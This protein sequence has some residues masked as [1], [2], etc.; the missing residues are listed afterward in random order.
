MN[1]LDRLLELLFA[2]RGEQVPDLD[3][4]Q[5]ADCFRALCNV[6]P[7]RPAGEEFLRLQ[8]DYLSAQAAARGPVD[9]ADLG[10]G[11]AVLWRGDI[12]RLR[13]DAIVNACNPALLGC[14]HPLH[15]CIDNLIHSRAGVQVRLDCAA[16]MRGECEPNGRVRVT[17]AYNL[18]CRLIFHTV[19]PVVSGAVT[20]ENRQ[21]LR[22][23]Y[24]SCLAEAERRKLTGIAFCCLSTGVYRFPKR[25]ACRIALAAVE[26]WLA[27]HPAAPKVVFCVYTDED[28]AVYSA[29]FSNTSFAL[30]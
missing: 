7:P 29:E 21:D 15:N 3:E 16:T 20:E 18:P 14:F 2:E 27:V 10:G 24:I 11:R 25:E 23:C 1:P 19:G 6:R 22:A 30:R 5:K 4:S 28:E 12:T 9:A 26:D 8:D 17:A 13:V